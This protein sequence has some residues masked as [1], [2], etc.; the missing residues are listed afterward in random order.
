MTRSAGPS[1][2]PGELDLDDMAERLSKALATSVADETEIAWI[3]TSTR[4]ASAGRER[5]EGGEGT[6]EGAWRSVM[7]R[8]REGRRRGSF[9]T[10]T[11]EPGE[12]A[13][14][15]RQALAA[16]RA[17]APAPE[18][19]QD[20][21]PEPEPDEG[22]APIA[23]DP[24]PLLWDPEVARLDTALARELLAQRV[25]G[26]ERARLDWSLTRVAVATSAGA[27]RRAQATAVT[28]GVYSGGSDGAGAGRAAASARSLA[29]LDLPAIVER[30]RRRAPGSR[31]GPLPGP[32]LGGAPAAGPVI[33]SQ[34][35]A[36]ALVEL[37]AQ[38]ALSSRAF[39]APGSPLAGL[40]DEHV[41]SPTVSLIDDGLD[42]AGLPFPFDLLGRR[43]RRMAMVEGGVVRTPAVT[44]E[45]SPRVRRPPTPHAVGPDEARPTNLFLL[46]P[47]VPGRSGTDET[48]V[49]AAAEGGIW[50]G[51][52]HGLECFDPGRV[53]ARARVRGARRV[54]G[55]TLGEPLPELVWEDSLLRLFSQVRALG[56]EPVRLSD[57]RLPGGTSAPMVA[58]DGAET[59]RPLA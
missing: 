9:R 5:S 49:L 30:A 55:G 4:T 24:T 52:L 56:S 17:A 19:E 47:S 14:G 45:L 40:L 41:L 11:A 1:P 12:I 31:L 13:S 22:E 2:R 3:E 34:E 43:K 21:E 54:R 36:C 6:I 50:I 26:T 46:P 15:I 48:E 23:G 28:L 59:L 29:D 58:V 37:L 57:H 8:V 35:A 25:G 51:S 18:P 38:A 39:E 20:P 44:D 53:A 42:P 7:V 10:G 27:L 16:S 33:F 32:G